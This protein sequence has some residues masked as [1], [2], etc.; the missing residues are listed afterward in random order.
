[1]MIEIIYTSV[2][3]E[4]F[5]NPHILAKY[6]KYLSKVTA[7][8]TI[9]KEAFILDPFARNQ[10]LATITNDL[11]PEFQTTYNLEANEFMELMLEEQIQ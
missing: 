7:G 9:G 6:K 1:M 5:N 4:P 3:P 11:N 8:L 10:R 2:S